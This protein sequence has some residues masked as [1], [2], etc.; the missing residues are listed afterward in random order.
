LEVVSEMIEANQLHTSTPITLL[1]NVFVCIREVVVS[2]DWLNTKLCL[3]EIV[4]NTNRTP[5]KLF[6]INQR[7][8]LGK[9][10]PLLSTKFYLPPKYEAS[11]WMASTISLFR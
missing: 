2:R 4:F 9:Y 3:L 5:V 11:L 6:T 7:R 1:L 8:E 10:I